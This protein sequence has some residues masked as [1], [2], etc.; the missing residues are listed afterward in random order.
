MS[1]KKPAAAEGA[2][3][4]AAAAAAAKKKKMMVIII[5]AVVLLAGGGGGAFVFMGKKDPAAAEA[6]AA[7]EAPVGPPVYY[8]FEQPFTSNL[9][10]GTT[11]YEVT[12]I[13]LHVRVKDAKASE[14]MKTYA[15]EVRGAILELLSSKTGDEILSPEGK[16]ALKD[17]IKKT[18][19]GI[20]QRY[21]KHDLIEDVIFT[22]FIVQ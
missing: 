20:T 6:E 12:Q 8:A 4:D 13:A 15:P 18:L 2:E 3:G 17:A 16:A 19:N 9:Q 22:S 14:A 1:D 11:G 21:E 7:H 5:A 10:S